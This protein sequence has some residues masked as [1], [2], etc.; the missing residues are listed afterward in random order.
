MSFLSS[1]FGKKPAPPSRK[2]DESVSI[3]F[4][5]GGFVNVPALDSWRLTAQARA[6]KDQRQQLAANAR[7]VAEK[8][9]AATEYRSG[10][11]V[12]AADREAQLLAQQQADQQ[13]RAALA[14]ERQSAERATTAKRQQAQS[15]ALAE[16]APVTAQPVAVAERTNHART[17]TQ[18]PQASLGQQTHSGPTELY[19]FFIIS[20]G[21]TVAF[22]GPLRLA[23]AESMAMEARL[24]GEA[25][26][27][28]GAGTKVDR[29]WRGPG[30]C[31]YVYQLPGEGRYLLGSGSGS[32]ETEKNKN[33]HISNGKATIHHDVKC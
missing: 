1:I 33:G 12:A 8:E 19:V 7:W 5:V 13:R 30:Q 3:D 28:Y 23:L 2:A 4:E 21:Q 24:Q 25:P 22:E 26:G 16:R 9:Q 10:Q 20:G 15:A 17:A 6:A 32:V 27:K 29:R 14:A 11:V 31:L 18:T